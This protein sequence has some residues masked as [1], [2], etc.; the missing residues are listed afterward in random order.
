MIIIECKTYLYKRLWDLTT[1]W[2]RG[3]SLTL[4]T[5]VKKVTRNKHLT[6]ICLSSIFDYVHVPKATETL[7]RGHH[8]LYHLGGPIL[9]R[10]RFKMSGVVVTLAKIDIPHLRHFDTQIDAVIFHVWI[11]EILSEEGER[12]ENRWLL[13][14]SPKFMQKSPFDA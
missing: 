8:A 14:K 4:S 7:N 12:S 10:T 5:V 9:K 2:G 1:T 3:K 13:L 11:F 6:N